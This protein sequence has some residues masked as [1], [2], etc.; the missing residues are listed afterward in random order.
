M[1]VLCTSDV[2][3]IICYYGQS[4]YL[5]WT[6]IGGRS[7]AGA[8]FESLYRMSGPNHRPPSVEV[9]GGTRGWGREGRVL[10]PAALDPPSVH[11][12]TQMRIETTDHGALDKNAV[13]RGRLGQL[14][15]DN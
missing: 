5:T 1:S 8:C 12:T 3:R 7:M 11:R 2:H 15:A 14:M 13:Q 10:T 9:G 4:N 6:L